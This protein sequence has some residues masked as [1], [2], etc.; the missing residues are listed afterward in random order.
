MKYGGGVDLGLGK[1][2]RIFTFPSETTQK[3]EIEALFRL[4]ILPVYDITLTIGNPRIRLNRVMQ[5]HQSLQ[6]IPIH[7]SFTV[8]C[9]IA[10]SA[11]QQCF[12]FVKYCTEQKTI[13]EHFLKFIF[14]KN[15]TRGINYLNMAK[16]VFAFEEKLE[17]H[18]KVYIYKEIGLS[19]NTTLIARNYCKRITELWKRRKVSTGKQ[20]LCIQLMFFKHYLCVVWCHTAVQTELHHKTKLQSPKY[21]GN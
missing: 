9:N 3:F 2:P 21:K 11:T 5:P 4:R 1:A 13:Y 20:M 18:Y 17:I 8:K 19:Y 16:K 6:S 15:Q 10:I 7:S 12:I 14:M